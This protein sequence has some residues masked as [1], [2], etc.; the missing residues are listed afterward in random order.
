M[1]R[2]AILG[3]GTVGSGVIDTL[4]KNEKSIAERAGGPVVVKKIFDR[5]DFDGSPVQNLMTKNIA[6]I[7]DDEEIHIVVEVM[8]GVE[9]AHTYA[10]EAIL[11]GKSVITSNKELVASH[12]AELLSLARDKNVN[13]LFEASVCGGIPIIR[14]LNKSLTADEISEI[15]GILNGTTNY[16][17]TKMDKEGIDFSEA[18]SYAQ[19]CGYAEKDPTNDV[20]GFDSARKT[21]ILLSLATGQQ[22]DYKSIHTEGIRSVTERHI[23]YAGEIGGKIKPVSCAHIMED[24]VYAY[25]APAIVKNGHPI[26]IASG[27]HNAVYIR[28]NVMGELMFYGLG[29][30]KMPT[31]SSVVADIIDAARHEYL[32]IM[33][34]WSKE[35]KGLT[36][37]NREF[38]VNLHVCA[39]NDYNRAKEFVKS[40]FP[41]AHV[42]S[43]DGES[44]FAFLAHGLAK[45]LSREELENGSLKEWIS[46]SVI[47][48]N[49]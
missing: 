6:D 43:L 35:Q 49:E 26:S 25:V 22:V 1:T 28:G 34:M 24:K 4:T 40:L 46:F 32:H 41:E 3:Y 27:V 9:P 48:E 33:H 36:P 17:L 18:L 20:D 37:W 23:K 11:R 29:A 47:D 44:D 10:R 8:G 15:T 16:I 19:E 5:R 30:G 14:P 42:F 21:A 12:G 31:A 45:E 2:I 39:Y 38:V 7:L 13:F